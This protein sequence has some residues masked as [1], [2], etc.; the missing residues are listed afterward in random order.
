MLRMSVFI[1]YL[2]S[3][4]KWLT[5][6]DSKNILK[7]SKLLTVYTGNLLVLT[8]TLVVIVVGTLPYADRKVVNWKWMLFCYHLYSSSYYYSIECSI[9][10]PFPTI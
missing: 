4:F 2:S 3:M 7:T 6:H 1:S 8:D 10:I 9:K 5:I